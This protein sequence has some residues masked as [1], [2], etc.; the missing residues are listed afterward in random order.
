MGVYSEKQEVE[1]PPK[2]AHDQNQTPMF[3]EEYDNE[4]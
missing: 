2:D 4:S 1:L 3:E